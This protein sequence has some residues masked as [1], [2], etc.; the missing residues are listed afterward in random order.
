MR[1]R[2]VVTESTNP[3]RNLAFE[4][5]LFGFVGKGEVILYLWQNDFTV[6]IGRNQ[7]IYA[8][9][10]AVEFVSD[11]GKIARRMSGGGAV[12]HDMGNL[13]F[14]IICQSGEAG[15]TPYQD[16]I[17]NALGGFGIHVGFNGRNDLVVDDRKFS[18]NAVY[19]DGG[20]CC[21]HGTILVNTDI[22]KMEYYLTPE[23]SK[24][25]RNHVQSVAS[26]VVNLSEVSGAVTVETMKKAVIASVGGVPLDLKIDERVLG[27][28][29][30]FFLSREWIYGGTT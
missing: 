14:S 18:G 24:L 8:E 7:D 17:I 6:V 12:Y 30:K 4:Q 28:R 16:I 11:G 25:E 10:K 2:Y 20:V 21:Q 27:D 1:Y 22:S 13:N 19:D 5:Y 23:K 29:E 26:R 15:K 9:C 3:Y